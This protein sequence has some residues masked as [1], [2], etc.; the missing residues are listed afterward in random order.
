MN[1]H[2]TIVVECQSR[3]QGEG[4]PTAGPAANDN[5]EDDSKEEDKGWRRSTRMEGTHDHL[6]VVSA[7]KILRETV[8]M[9]AKIAKLGGVIKN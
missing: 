4:K 9:E 1:R 2:A 6:Q 5:G 7:L 3:A 8:A